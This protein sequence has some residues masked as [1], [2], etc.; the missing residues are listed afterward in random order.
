MRKL[1]L[2]WQILI[3]IFLAAISGWVVNKLIASGI[4]DPKLFNFNQ[5]PKINSIIKTKLK[6]TKKLNIRYFNKCLTIFIII[7]SKFLLV[8]LLLDYFCQK[9]IYLI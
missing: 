2:H 5:S 3:A 8:F 7:N 1:E 4:D 9:Y 6:K